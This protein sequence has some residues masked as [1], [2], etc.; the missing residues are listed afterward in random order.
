MRSI[1]AAAALL[2]AC[3]NSS[4]DPAAEVPYREYADTGAAVRAI[5]AEAG[6]VQ[7]YAVGEYHPTTQLITRSPLKQF[8]DDVL[9]RLAPW[10][11]DLVV[12]TWFDATCAPADPVQAQIQAVTQRPP[13]GNDLRALVQSSLPTHGL[14]MT[15]IEHSSML[16]DKGRVDFYRLLATIA[17]K[18]HE[19]TA[20]LTRSGHSVI[21]YGG[22]LH[23]DL[24][25]RW[26]LDE[27]S[28]AAPLAKETTVLE[29][30]LAVPEVVTPMAGI[31][32]EDWYPLLSRAAPD[33]V[34]VWE[35]GANSYVVILP[36]RDVVA[37]N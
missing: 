25:P 34:L 14:A 23:N 27:L 18:L 2:I 29:L 13:I 6:N 15:C 5:L 20:R 19:T 26:M 7:V 35:R 11:D 37:T 17:D 32:Q 24:Y 22:A 36:S 4:Y 1:A 33:K 9:G 8:T 3:D 30:D 21:V 16:D 28:Y 10:A 12:E 31:T